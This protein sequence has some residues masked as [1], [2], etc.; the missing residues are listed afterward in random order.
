MPSAVGSQE[1]LHHT[2]KRWGSGERSQSTPNRAASVSVAKAAAGT[3]ASAHQRVGA[4]C[5]GETMRAARCRA[6]R[7]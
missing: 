7:A 6:A 2:Q 3:T 5:I 4:V 1:W